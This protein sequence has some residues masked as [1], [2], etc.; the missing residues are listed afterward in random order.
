MPVL[1]ESVPEYQKFDRQA[2][3]QGPEMVRRGAEASVAPS[4]LARLSAFA[5]RPPIASL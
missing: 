4:K 3:E 2:L 5:A 1:R